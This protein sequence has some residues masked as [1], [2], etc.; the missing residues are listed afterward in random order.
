MSIQQLY[1]KCETGY[2][3]AFRQIEQSAKQ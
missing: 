2:E 3:Y 1:E